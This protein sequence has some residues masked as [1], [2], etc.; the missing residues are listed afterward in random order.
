MIQKSVKNAINFTFI[1]LT[2]LTFALIGYFVFSGWANSSERIITKIQSNINKQIFIQ[3]DDFLNIPLNINET[4][5]TLIENQIIDLHNRQARNM[6]F[7]GIVSANDKDVYS[8]SYGTEAGEYYGARRNIQNEVEVYE[9]TPATLG[10]SRYYSL[11]PDLTANELVLETP[12]FDPRTREWYVFAKTFKKPT[13]SPIYKHFIMNDLTVSAAYPIIKN[14]EVYG[15]LGTHIILSKINSFLSELAQDS[16]GTIFVIEKKSGYLVAN[17]LNRLNYETLPNQQIRRVTLEEAGGEIMNSAY[18][19]YLQNSNPTYTA[20][21]DDGKIHVQTIEYKKDGLEWLILSAIPDKHFTAEITN[22]MRL[23]IILSILAFF[24]AIALYAANTN[25]ILKPIYNL[26]ETTEKF[27]RGIF[28]DRA[29]IFKKDEIGQLSQAFNDMA[30][31]IHMLITTLEDK[32]RDRTAELKKTNTELALR[33][34]ELD[35]EKNQAIKNYQELATLHTIAAKVQT[36]FLPQFMENEFFTIQH[37]YKPIQTLSGDMLDYVWL[38]E[39]KTLCGFVVDVSGHGLVAALRT[40]VL[41]GII[42]EV[43]HEKTPL[44]EK[45]RNINQLSLR[46]FDEYSY[47]TMVYFEFDFEN[48]FLK[49]VSGGNN[50]VLAFCEHTHGLLRIPGSFIGMFADNTDFGEIVLP[51]RPG[52]IF[53]FCSDG[54]LELLKSNELQSL[55]HASL[56]SFLL[57]KTEAEERWDDASAIVLEIKK[58]TT[59][60]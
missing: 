9:N 20:Y 51:I 18:Q 33:T 42:N 49:I 52:D 8:I 22:S 29:T 59:T 7:A 17:S 53:A 50:Y 37:I 5:K 41:H 44:H 34:E 10:K 39:S 54:L 12:P 38:P 1:I 15:V 30:D 57:N 36:G 2:G 55:D 23:S 40:N 48:Y 32:I 58:Q 60:P 3:I 35:K 6:Y 25:K 43:F 4:N 11:N 45:L 46:Y 47:A 26:I 28:L 13:F 56:Y 19:N 14:G 24:T 27:S 16:R 21:T 31:Q